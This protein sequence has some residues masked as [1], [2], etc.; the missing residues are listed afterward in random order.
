MA[1][2]IFYNFILLSSTFFVWLSEKGKGNLERYF[3]LGLAFLLVFIPS[4]IR[5][6]IG[7]DY[8]NYLEIYENASLLESYRLK[9]PAFYFINFFLKNYDSHFQWMFAT[10]SF[11]FTAVAFKAYPR[12]NA[13]LLHFLFFLM[14]W[15][16][17]FNGIRQALA[18]SWCLLA[19]FSFF[20]RRYVW[21]VLLT[22]VGS[23]F[24][25]SALIFT[26]IGVACMVPL[27]ERIKSYI[28]PLAF[29]AFIGFTFVAMN[30]VLIYIEQILQL[31]GLTRYAN[32]FNSARHFI[33]RDFGS[34][35]GI[36]AKI[37]FSFYIIFNT[38]HFLRLNKQ[39]WFL[40]VLVFAYTVS[41]VLANSIIIFARMADVFA[42]APIVSAYLLLQLPIN[43]Q[44]HKLALACFMGFL[45]LSFIKESFGV[46]TT[47]ADPKRNPYQTI[48]SE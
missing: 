45:L 46:P 16:F 31:L 7:T 22:L 32:Y 14:L 43:R 44:I 36:L 30:V 40:I 10:F 4:A 41:T 24:H 47:Y 38:K 39:Y 3:F 2:V 1:T 26:M 23:T 20:E 34:G 21:F 5:Y 11:V 37:L 33:A 35:I 18:L 6:D 48:F 12:K 29:I 28:A 13:W 17:S 27:N 25:Q 42:L 19:L 15:F 9:E 8:V